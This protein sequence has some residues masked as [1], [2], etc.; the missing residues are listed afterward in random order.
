MSRMSRVMSSGP[1]K[2]SRRAVTELL[3]A[4]LL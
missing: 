4:V 2:R 1:F 3:A